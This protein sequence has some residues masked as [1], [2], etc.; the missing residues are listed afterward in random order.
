V[1]ARGSELPI[2]VAETNCDIPAQN[3][4]ESSPMFTRAAL[5]LLVAGLAQPLLV[6]AT[7]RVPEDHKTIQAA[8][9]AAQAGDTVTVAPGKYPER[10]RLKAGVTLW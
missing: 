2:T 4:E 10:V 8:I 7:V 1:T 5:T 9:D 6:A 3:F